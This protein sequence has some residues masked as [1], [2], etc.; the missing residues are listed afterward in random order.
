M[1][2]KTI[3]K[4]AS[5]TAQNKGSFISPSYQTSA[6]AIGLPEMA[7]KNSP[8]KSV[9]CGDMSKTSNAQII[10]ELTRAR[11]LFQLRAI[12]AAIKGGDNG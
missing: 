4:T 5:K 7:C 8:R 11:C 12:C 3:V 10:A 6:S 9:Y 1:N 2:V